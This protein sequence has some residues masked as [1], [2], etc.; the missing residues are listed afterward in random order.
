MCAIAAI[1][2]YHYAAPEINGQELCAIRDH[3][4]A[5]GPDGKGTWF[6]EN[7]KIGL[8]YQRLSIIDINERAAQPMSSADGQFW[9]K[10]I[11]SFIQKKL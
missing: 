1:Y 10:A 7:G 6:S 2:N 5:R 9:D 11:T 3:M 8:A 4:S